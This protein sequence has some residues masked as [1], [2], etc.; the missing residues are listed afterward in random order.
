[1]FFW[2]FPAQNGD[3]NAPLIIWLQGGPGGSSMF[4]LFSE[5]GPWSLD[6]KLNL[7]PRPETWNGK[8]KMLFI[9]NPV[10][11]GYSSPATEG[12]YCTNTRECVAANLHSLL[13][14]VLRAIIPPLRRTTVPRRSSLDAAWLPGSASA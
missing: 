3:A 10:G 4:G 6:E 12:G 1:M 11:A 5:M 8:Y 13:T 14:Q 9:D 7:I 2:Y